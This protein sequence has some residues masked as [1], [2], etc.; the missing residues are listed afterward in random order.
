MIIP[1]RQEEEGVVRW[2]FP[3]GI[4]VRDGEVLRTSWGR[5]GCGE[6][7]CEGVEVVPRDEAEE[8]AHG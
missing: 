7:V 8:G 5:V 6:L 1:E 2:L 3:D 4:V